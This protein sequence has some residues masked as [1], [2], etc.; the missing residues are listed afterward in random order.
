MAQFMQMLG[1]ALRE[2]GQAMDRLG[3]AAMDL[4]NTFRVPLSRHRQLMNL[5]EKVPVTSSAAWVAPSATAIGDVSVAANSSIWYGTVLRG[6]QAPIYIGTDTNVQ[7]LST[8][9]T[10]PGAGVT[11]GA[12][13]T[14]G[15]KAF[16]HACTVGDGTLIGMGSQVRNSV[17][18][19]AAM[20]AAGAVVSNAVV[21]T[22]QLWAGNPAKHIRDL[23]EQEI[24][25]MRR[26]AEQYSALAVKHR[27]DFMDVADLIDSEGAQAKST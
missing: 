5:G 27:Q 1:R 26:Q 7:D 13:V 8:I 14:V 9:T 17:V 25:A 3:L 24:E 18:E 22:G 4:E 23:T 10:S 12:K 16:L 19:G 2:T 21:Q 11:L 15:H 20:V 6:D